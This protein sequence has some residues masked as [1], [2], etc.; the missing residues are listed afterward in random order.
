MAEGEGRPGP[1]DDARRGLPEDAELVCELNVFEDEG[2]RRTMVAWSGWILLAGVA[3]L[4]VMLLAGVP[5]SGLGPWRTLA[6]MA[7]GTVAAFVCHELVHGLFFRILGGPGTH[8]RFGAK[9]G[10]LYTE[11]PG[12][13]LSAPRYVVACLAPAVVISIATIAWGV[14]AQAPYEALV[15]GVLHLTGCTGDFAFV[16]SICVYRP[17]YA[18]DDPNGLRLYISHRNSSR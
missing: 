3:A 8:V 10:M 17:T 16:R 6:T 14:V 7:A 4:A 15:V 2:L 5:S 12:L 13:V 9:D 11:A 1:A 18:G